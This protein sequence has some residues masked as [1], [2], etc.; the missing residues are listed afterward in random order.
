[1]TESVIP[2]RTTSE[3]AAAAKHARIK[4]IVWDLDNTLWDGTLLEGDKV[5][6]RDKVRETILELDSCGILHSIAS[7]NH[8]VRRWRGCAN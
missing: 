7:R 8:A 3:A 4:C 1:M 6:L 2:N 5:R